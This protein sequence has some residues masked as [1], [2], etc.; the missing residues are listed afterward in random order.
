MKPNI[1]KAIDM[2][3]AAFNRGIKCAPVLD[4]EFMQTLIGREVGDHRSMAEMR[5]WTQG[6]TY[7]NLHFEHNTRFPS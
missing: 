7:A 4:G 2:G 5:A 1:E 6:W 3:K